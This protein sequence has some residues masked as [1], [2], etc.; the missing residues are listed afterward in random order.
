MVIAVPCSFKQYCL[1]QRRERKC[2]LAVFYP[3]HAPPLDPE[4][5]LCPH[6]TAHPNQTEPA[7]NPKQRPSSGHERATTQEHATH[8]SDDDTINAGGLN[9]DVRDNARDDVH[10][11][12]PHSSSAIDIAQIPPTLL[13]ALQ[14]LFAPN[15]SSLDH[16]RY[17]PSKHLSPHPSLPRVFPTR[18]QSRSKHLLQESSILQIMQMRGM[19]PNGSPSP[20]A[21]LASDHIVVE[22]GAGTAGLARHYQLCVLDNA[23]QAGGEG[24]GSPRMH[25][26]LVDRQKFRSRRQTDY[27]LRRDGAASARR[28]VGDVAACEDVAQLVRAAAKVVQEDDDDRRARNETDT[29]EEQSGQGPRLTQTYTLTLLAKHFCGSATDAALAWLAASIPTTPP[30]VTCI[31]VCVATC[32][33]A[34]C[35]WETYA[36]QG[37]FYRAIA[38]ES[39]NEA[40]RLF[41]WVCRLSSWATLPLDPEERDQDGSPVID[42]TTRAGRRL[43]GQMCKRLIDRGRMM[44]MENVLAARGGKTEV[45]VVEY[46]RESPERGLLV[47]WV[48]QV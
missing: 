22:F 38:A 13:S 2:H 16:I 36:N 44:E 41:Q 19:L 40:A 43:C 31:N 3:D 29:A 17:P 32:C 48:H 20:T 24:P 4:T 26:Y 1:R 33:H 42:I 23:T 21:F 9:P 46:T 28:F 25:F 34:L 30:T 5:V 6:H 47:G 12:H 11:I 35:T 27:M 37:Y 10:N 14:R 45:E 39:D 7:Q 18:G 15:A 8:H